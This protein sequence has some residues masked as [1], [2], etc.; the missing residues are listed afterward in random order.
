MDVP[1]KFGTFVFT[2]EIVF[3]TI[4]INQPAATRL[5]CS[6]D[7]KKL[8]GRWQDVLSTAISSYR[9]NEHCT[10]SAPPQSFS[11]RTSGSGPQQLVQSRHP[12]QNQNSPSPSGLRLPSNKKTIYDRNLNRSRNAEIGRSTFAF[13]F[14]AMVS[15]AQNRVNGIQELEQRYD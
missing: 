10:M 15:Y 3:Q 4:A 1:F 9:C 12:T 7:A 13:L 11:D 14:M 2:F 5:L 8:S 6:S